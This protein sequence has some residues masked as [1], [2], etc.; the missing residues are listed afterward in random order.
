MDATLKKAIDRAIAPA[1]ETVQ[2]AYVISEATAR[3]FRDEWDMLA[4]YAS[5]AE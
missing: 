5:S 1:Y 4:E 2:K 3:A